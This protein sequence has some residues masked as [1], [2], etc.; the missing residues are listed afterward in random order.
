MNRY[1][2]QRSKIVYTLIFWSVLAASL[3]KFSQADTGGPVPLPDEKPNTWHANPVGSSDWSNHFQATSITQTHG[4][5][6]SPY[7]GTYSLTPNFEIPTSFTATLFVGHRLGKDTF[8]FINPEESIGA[9]LSQTHGIAG[10]PNGEIYRVDDPNPKTNLSRLFVQ[11]DFGFGG[12]REPVEDQPNQFA[13][14]RDERRLTLVAGK[15]SLNDYFDDNTYSHDPRT[16]F[17]NWALMDNASWD[18]AADTRGYTWG[19]FIEYHIADWSFRG[20]MVQEPASANGLDLD[21]NIAHAHG[22]N[23]EIEHRFKIADHPGKVRLL[24]YMNHALMGN[25]REA[26]AAAAGT[27]LTPDVT[28][29]RTYRT[30]YGLGLN[31]EQ[32]LSTDLGIFSRI[33][34]NDGT[35]ETWAFTEVERSYSVGASL[36]GNAWKRPDDVV[37]LALIVNSIGKDHT[38]YLRAGGIG[39]I[40]GEGPAAG[41]PVGGPYLNDAP[42]EIVEAYYLYKLTPALGITPDFQFVNN[43]GYNSDRGPV[44]IFSLRLHLE[45]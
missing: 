16:Q 41:S 15:F 39:F 21:G 29:T 17:M 31:F 10:F 28:A 37:G 8:V 13:G 6:R 42:E 1:N 34:W 44:A 38:D 19:F 3:I 7:Q 30:K 45:I 43:P 23:F 2:S 22:D 14:S 25:Y 36:K 35:T 5:F 20:A 4:S 33:G 12:G 40:V 11:K 26:I 9:G 18:Y 24:G 32:E 27:G